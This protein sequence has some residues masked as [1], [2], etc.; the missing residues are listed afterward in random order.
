MNIIDALR[1]SCNYFFFEIGRLSGINNI[2]HYAMGV[3]LGEKTGIELEGEKAGTLASPENRKEKGEIWYSAD[4]IQAA[5][6]QSD[7]LF[8]P[9]QL[10]NY[11]S[12]L[13]NGG[14]RN[15]THILKS[16]K[17]YDYAHT[18]YEPEMEILGQS[19]ISS[20]TEDII[21]EGMLAVSERGSAAAIFS[22]YPIKVGSK[23]G[24]AQTG[25]GSANGIFVAYAPYDD[26]E[27]AVAV[28]VERAGKGS[29]IGVIARDIFDAYF[30][31]NDVLEVVTEENSLIN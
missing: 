9:L 10:A 13:V 23:T 6:G 12:T 14:N 3:G 24:T 22:G 19:G 16:V 26:P 5:I 1:V 21:K 20:E 29:R 2:N 27:I 18:L 15:K 4:T 25:R 8:T 31:I 30:R 11:V 17:S 7:N 28:V